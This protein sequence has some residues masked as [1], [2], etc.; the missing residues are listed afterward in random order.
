MPSSVL[1]VKSCRWRAGNYESIRRK[2]ILQGGS[3]PKT[4]VTLANPQ[5]WE[6]R[7]QLFRLVPSDEFALYRSEKASSPLDRRGETTLAE[8]LTALD[9]YL[10]F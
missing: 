2:Y 1:G 10:L 3:E 7:D 4:V 8:M 5:R 6:Y 9:M